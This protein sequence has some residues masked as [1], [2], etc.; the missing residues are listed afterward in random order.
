MAENEHPAD[1][2]NAVA[3]NAVPANAVPVNATS[4]NPAAPGATPV[5]L[6]Q[7]DNPLKRL[8]VPALLIAVL[9]GPVIWGVVTFF[10]DTT[11]MREN[12][13]VVFQQPTCFS[14]P[15]NISVP[16]VQ[17]PVFQPTVPVTQPRRNGP[18]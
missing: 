13:N 4:P 7:F 16:T 2:T 17:P 1:G 6:P 15:S 18:R 3:A 9:S 12:Y 8:I 11:R 5:E 10:Q 14:P